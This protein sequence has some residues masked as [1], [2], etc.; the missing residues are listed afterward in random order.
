MAAESIVL[1]DHLL[2]RHGAGHGGLFAHE[3]GGRAEGE[4]GHVPDRL[5]GRR[6]YPALGDHGLEGR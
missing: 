6:P 5:Q 1:V 2:D 4:A 3:G